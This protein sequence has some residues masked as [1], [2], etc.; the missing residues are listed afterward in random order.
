VAEEDTDPTSAA[1]GRT[2]VVIESVTP[3]VDDGRFAVKRIV[4]DPVVVEADAFADGNDQ[5]ACVL[6]YR[7]EDEH[8]WM[9]VPMQALG[10]DRWR[11]QFTA[12]DIGRYRYTVMAWVDHFEGWRHDLA[13]RPDTDSD[14]ALAFLI[15][16]ER[17]ARAAACASG[18]DA[19]RL[20]SAAQ[21]LR[22]KA[23]IDDKR[24]L[25]LDGEIAVLVGRH[26]ER[27]FVTR[28][29]RELTLVVDRERARFSAWYEFFP[30][31]CAGGDHGNFRD[32][33]AMLRYI[34]SMGFDVVYLPPIHPIGRS[35][36][37]GRNNTLG[38]GPNDVGSPWAIGTQE[39][40]GHK[41]VHPALG[42]LADFHW[43]VSTAREH[44][45]EV[46][47]DV[48]FQCAPDHPYVR[49]HPEWFR[50]RPDGS[51]QYAE[52]PPKKYQDIYPFDFESERGRGLWE[53][54]RSVFLFWIDQG[55]RLFR[56][57]NPHTKPFPF[58][59]WVI[60]EIK[61]RHPDVI[62]LSEAFTRPK[63]MH[64]LAKL[65]FSQSY[66]YF[67]W[68]NT[69]SELVEYFTELTQ[70]GCRE[71]LRPHVWPNTPDILSEYLQFG[72]RPAFMVRLVL[73]ATLAASYGIYGPAFEFAEAR[74][75]EPGS[76]EYL[77][78]EKY[79][80]RSWDLD[81]PNSLRDF[82]ARVNRIRREHVALQ[83]DWS[84]RFHDI[85]N[86]RLICYSKTTADQ[87]DIILVVINLDPHHIQAGWLELPPDLVGL[88]GGL[89]Y[90]A[91]DLLTD[92]RY[93]WYG[94]RNYVELDPQS[95]PAQIFRLR[96]RVRREHDFDYYM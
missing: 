16:A 73:A 58:W 21:L 23:A 1:E 61:Q 74:A 6:L 84:L 32:C 7:R 92:A 10:N 64:R 75:L 54:L 36:R 62:L 44:N 56:V 5:I 24:R 11:A 48:A 25:A 9:E 29:D 37:K 30:R 47:L 18:S 43:F 27:R 57:D 52:N 71:Y 53:E 26:A 66:T 69:K 86:D 19:E 3:Q 38:A 31:S 59:E 28:Y 45:L 78:S 70:S 83:S 8:E 89:P 34:A 49:E 87:S 65:G 4:D 67:T 39:E 72:G 94:T 77:D 60:R 68:R 42:T 91:H 46:A 35:F 76:E 96:R 95:D 82:I 88:P 55:V 79:E 13:K 63:V 14:L 90:Q 33:A 15:G 22:G 17:I 20:A 12:S 50:A 81:R 80:R 51:V 41:S 40:G 2:R 93:L 85:D